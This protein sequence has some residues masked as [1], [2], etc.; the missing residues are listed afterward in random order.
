MR[1]FKAATGCSPGEAIVA[2]T[3]HPAVVL[4]L[5]KERGTL[6]HC[7]RADLTILNPD[8]IVQATCIAGEVVWCRQGSRF[9][10]S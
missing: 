3:H 6:A 10:V 5:E 9:T 8:L 1:H 7:A 2:A 4:G